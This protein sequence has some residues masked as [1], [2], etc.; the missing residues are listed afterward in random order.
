[1]KNYPNAVAEELI[2]QEDDKKVIGAVDN[3]VTELITAL[4]GYRSRD[5]TDI[6]RDALI[7]KCLREQLASQVNMAG[8]LR[9]ITG[10]L[11]DIREA[12][13]KLEQKTQ[14]NG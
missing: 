9:L 7:A 13:H 4:R 5:V 12:L 11:A 6:L 2:A 1:M 3:A 14:P 10:L 8:Q